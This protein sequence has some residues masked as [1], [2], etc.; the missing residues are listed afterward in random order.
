MPVLLLGTP[1]GTSSS[2]LRMTPVVTS[3]GSYKQHLKSARALPAWT[4]PNPNLGI[5]GQVQGMRRWGQS[6]TDTLSLPC[7]SASTCCYLPTSLCHSAQTCHY[8]RPFRWSQTQSEKQHQDHASSEGP[9]DSWGL[10]S[11]KTL[12]NWSR[13]V[14]ECSVREEGCP[15]KREG[16]CGWD[17]EGVTL[18]GPTVHRVSTTRPPTRRPRA[19][20][21]GTPCLV[22]QLVCV[23]DQP[24]GDSADPRRCPWRRPTHKAHLHLPWVSEAPG[25]PKPSS[26]AKSFQPPLPLFLEIITKAIH[27]IEPKPLFPE[28]MSRSAQF[29]WEPRWA[30]LDCATRQQVRGSHTEAE[31]L[32]GDG[33][34]SGVTCPCGKGLAS[35]RWMGMSLPHRKSGFMGLYSKASQEKA[36]EWSGLF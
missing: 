19:C 20:S 27:S 25:F 16:S 28:N 10:P 30:P 31:N 6:L 15:M 17:C 22:A 35:C 21:R 5:S 13:E 36:G 23:S 29:F 26:S 1:P 14:R 9:G 3:K 24:H 8:S 18:M 33:G 7:K 11:R 2:D 12:S 32:A 4:H 34:F